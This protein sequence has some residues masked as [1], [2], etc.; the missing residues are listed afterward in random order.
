MMNREGLRRNGIFERLRKTGEGD[1]T[2]K[3]VI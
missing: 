3:G 2:G 1:P